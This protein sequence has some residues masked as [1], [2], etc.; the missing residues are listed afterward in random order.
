M[1][2]LTGATTCASS[3]Q[4]YSA[5]GAAVDAACHCGGLNSW[6]TSEQ[7]LASI[8]KASPSWLRRRTDRL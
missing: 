1:R 6:T 3:Q 7:T 2:G 4:K 5:R 8:K